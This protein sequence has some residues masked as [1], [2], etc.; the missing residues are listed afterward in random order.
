[1]DGQAAVRDPHHVPPRFLG[2]RLGEHRRWSLF[3][4]GDEGAVLAR[5]RSLIL[6]PLSGHPDPSRRVT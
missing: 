6:D 3:T 5:S 2:R 1:M 4:F